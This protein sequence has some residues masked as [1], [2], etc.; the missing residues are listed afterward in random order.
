MRAA[1]IG[2]TGFVGDAAHDDR[3]RG[4][5]PFTL[6]GFGDAA[7]RALEGRLAAR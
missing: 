3:I 5:L 2:A 6:T 1:V 4:L 7:R